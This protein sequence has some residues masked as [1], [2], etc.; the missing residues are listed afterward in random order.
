MINPNAK[1]YKPFARV[2]KDERLNIEAKVTANVTE[3]ETY[4]LRGCVFHDGIKVSDVPEIRRTAPNKAAA[5][6]IASEMLTKL[7]KIYKEINRKTV[8]RRNSSKNTTKVATYNTNKLV[9]SAFNTVKNQESI[10]NWGR[11]TTHAMITWFE[12]N[13]L[14]FLND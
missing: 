2:K 7:I 10:N 5:E 9:L 13:F 11:N 14:N 12:R 8:A 3:G 6:L 4:S 1:N